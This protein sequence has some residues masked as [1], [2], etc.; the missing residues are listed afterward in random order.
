MYTYE[1]IGVADEN[2]K[3]YE[4]KYGTY[5]KQQ[6][7]MLN[8]EGHKHIYN[9]GYESLINILFHENLW[10][11]K[12]EIKEMTLKE[13]EE[14]LGYRVRIVDPQPNKELSEKDKKEVDETIDMFGRL[15]GIKLNPEDYY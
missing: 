13:L 14:E 10:K 6:G 7:F 9:H 11:I 5:D 1:M 4:C 2:E 12:E 8:S 3:T 15:F